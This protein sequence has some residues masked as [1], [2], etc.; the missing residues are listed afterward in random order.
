M[1]PDR[2]VRVRSILLNTAVFN[3]KSARCRVVGL[4]G[5]KIESMG[6]FS[7]SSMIF[8]LNTVLKIILPVNLSGYGMYYFLFI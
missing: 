5:F 7:G 4:C 2:V 3:E 6:D 1:N 8:R